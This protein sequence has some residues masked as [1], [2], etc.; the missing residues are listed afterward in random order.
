MQVFWSLKALQ[1]Y[2]TIVDFLKSEWNEHVAQNFIIEVENVIDEIRKNLI[3]LKHQ[4]DIKMSGKA[5]SV[6]T[7]FFF[8]G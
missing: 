2:F 6:N 8:T 1:T 5:L 3:F 4:I 7:T